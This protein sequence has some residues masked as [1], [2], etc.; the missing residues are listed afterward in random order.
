MIFE[1]FY[2]RL[3]PGVDVELAVDI[4]EM[5]AHRLDADAEEIG[6]FLVEIPFG[7]MLQHFTLTV[8]EA[9]RLLFDGTELV[10]VLDHFASDMR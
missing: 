9:R 6:N 10:E 2:H 7:Q 1:I 5:A 8:G 3:R 4:T